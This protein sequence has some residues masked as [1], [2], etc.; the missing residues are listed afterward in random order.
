MSD[1]EIEAEFKKQFNY[2]PSSTDIETTLGKEFEKFM[3]SPENESVLP[4]KA[5][6]ENNLI[7]KYSALRFKQAITI[8]NHYGP[9][10]GLRRLQEIDPEVAPDVQRFLQKQQGD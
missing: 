4:A 5:R 9:E 3:T 10:V 1:A 8:L 7:E 6:F 2:S